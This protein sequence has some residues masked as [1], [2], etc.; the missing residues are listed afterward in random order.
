[1]ILCPVHGAKFDPVSGAPR[2]PPAVS[3]LTVFAARVVDGWVEVA[4]REA[5]NE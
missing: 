3:P 5:N 2:C 1:M 4:L